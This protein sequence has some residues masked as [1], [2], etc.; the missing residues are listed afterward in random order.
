METLLS[1]SNTIRTRDKISRD[2]NKIT[3]EVGKCYVRKFILCE[4]KKG[5]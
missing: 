1:R 3:V 4:H 2:I 5:T